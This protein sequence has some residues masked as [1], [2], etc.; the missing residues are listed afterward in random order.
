M[1]ARSGAARKAETGRLNA[2]T[3]LVRLSG[4]S[5][6]NPLR[7]LDRATPSD[8]TLA[9]SLA[10]IGLVVRLTSLDPDT[11][12]AD[13]AL[14]ASYGAH[15]AQTGDWLLLHVGFQIDKIPLFFWAEA[16]SIAL[17]GN[18][19]VG[20]RLVDL[21]ASLLTI[22]GVYVLARDLA[23][24]AAA[25]AAGLAFALSPFAI[26]FGASVFTDPFSICLGV[27]AL[28]LAR[29][30]HPVGAGLL[31]GLS[32]GG[33]VFGLAYLPL[34]AALLVTAPGARRGVALARFAVASAGMA[35]LLLG[36]M[37]L[38][39][40]AYGAPWFLSS[41][42]DEVGG[43]GLADISAWGSRASAWWAWLGYFAESNPIRLMAVVALAGALLAVIRNRGP[44]R[45]ALF[46]VLAFSPAYFGLLVVMTSPT[47]DRYAFYMLPSICVAVG[48]GVGEWLRMVRPLLLRRPLLLACT[49]FLLVRSVPIVGQAAE[50]SLFVGTRSDTTFSGYQELCGWVQASPDG[51]IVIW[52]HSL[53]WVLGY[54]LTGRQDG[55]YWYRDASSISVGNRPT[56][57]AFTGDDDR[58]VV[59]AE[60]SF[61]G[62]VTT[63]V[64]TIEIKRQPHFWIYRLER[65]QA[66]AG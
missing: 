64:E 62:V 57:L 52:N 39:T 7:L 2:G 23:G 47:F 61:R 42:L 66:D 17:L 45:W 58:E 65:G 63:L 22:A 29:R 46:A 10:I 27:G 16:V 34:A 33:K 14:Y 12:H 3:A 55:A 43:T 40:V 21:A 38:R 15:V 60:L 1:T 32:M 44:R 5:R 28:V 35:G 25:W 11:L 30:D 20:I 19:P 8:L 36:F 18:T 9:A 48:I 56:Y 13:E 24:R 51:P 26:L 53:S 31:V 4:A 54:C 41:T 37:A 59:V 50:G 49:V 6:W